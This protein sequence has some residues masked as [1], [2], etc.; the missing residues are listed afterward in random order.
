MF[1]SFQVEKLINLRTIKGRRQFLVRWKGY[2]DSADT[3]ENEKDLNCPTL[4]EEF[5]IEEKEKEKEMKS[6][7][8]VSAKTDK[9]KK[10]K[11]IPKKQTTEN[12][13]LCYCL[14]SLYHEILFVMNI[15]FISV[16]RRAK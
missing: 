6:P 4:I 3:W 10:S 5:L 16:F 12:G 7:K 11:S 2:G 14:Y 8:T 15:T 1:F 9:S 13:T